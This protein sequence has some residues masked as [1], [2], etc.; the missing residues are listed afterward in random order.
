MVNRRN[1]NNITGL[2]PATLVDLLRGRAD[3]QPAQRSYTFLADGENEEGQLTYAELDRQARAIGALLQKC[4]AE[5][6]R[7]LLLYSPSLEF[8]TAFFGCLYSG[9]IAVPVYP[10]DPARLNR[11]LPRFLA[12]ANDAKPMIALT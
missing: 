2:I 6:E 7:A 12:I 3:H 11:S 1:F 10:P 4:N 8:I 9:I 5:G